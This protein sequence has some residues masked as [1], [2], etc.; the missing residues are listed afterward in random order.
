MSDEQFI[1]LVLTHKPAQ[2]SRAELCERIAS[3]VVALADM[4]ERCE[5]DDTVIQQRIE[6]IRRARQA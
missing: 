3:L 6:A 5:L 1:R 2:M 4:A